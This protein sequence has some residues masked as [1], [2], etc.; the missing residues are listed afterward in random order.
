MSSS[1]TNPI[2]VIFG[3]NMVMIL[4]VGLGIV[5]NQAVVLVFPVILTAVHAGISLGWKDAGKFVLVAMVTGWVMEY[6]GLKY[7]VIF[8]GKYQYLG[9]WQM[10]GPVPI[11][12]VMYW[13]VFIYSGYTLAVTVVGKYISRYPWL[14]IILGALVT[15]SIDVYMDPIQVAQ[16]HWMWI[17]GGQFFGVPRG[18]FTGWFL[19]AAISLTIWGVWRKANWKTRISPT[20]KIFIIPPICMLV[21]AGEFTRTAFAAGLNDLVPIGLMWILPLPLLALA[22]NTAGLGKWNRKN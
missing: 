3:L 22:I 9:D 14:V 13:L 20:D 8:G 18:N 10:I 11:W 4:A 5:P 16:G 6:W 1:A 15:M 12:V 19:V 7:G 21:L 17:G 2:W